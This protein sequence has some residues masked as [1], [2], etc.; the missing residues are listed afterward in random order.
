MIDYSDL[1]SSTIDKLLTYNYRFQ[2]FSNLG[3]LIVSKN[4]ENLVKSKID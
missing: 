4:F 2:Q 1:N 3:N